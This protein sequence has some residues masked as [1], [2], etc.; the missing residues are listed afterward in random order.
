MLPASNINSRG[1]G[2]YDL[3]RL[4]IYFPATRLFRFACQLFSLDHR[5]H[6][7]TF[8]LGSSPIDF[9]ETLQ[10]SDLCRQTRSPSNA[11]D[12]MRKRSH[13]PERVCK[14]RLRA[15]K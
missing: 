9:I 12:R 10:R 13:A 3:Q 6:L 15:P 5:L 11:W 7:P 2:M 4:P 14:H 1:I 8:E